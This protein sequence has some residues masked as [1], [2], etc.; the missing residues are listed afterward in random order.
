MEQSNSLEWLQTLT[1]DIGFPVGF[2][3]WFFFFPSGCIGYG[4]L[5]SQEKMPVS[6]EA[7]GYS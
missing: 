7:N 2:R 5:A 1:A 4:I 3:H 6:A